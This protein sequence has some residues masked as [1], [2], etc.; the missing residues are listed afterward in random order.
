MNDLRTL[1][2]DPFST[3]FDRADEMS[4]RDDWEDWDDDAPLSPTDTLGEERLVALESQTA[5]RPTTKASDRPQYRSSIQ[6]PARLKS[7]LRQK[8]QNERAGIKLVTDM[9]KFKKQ[10]QQQ[11]HIAQQMRG[12]GGVPDR[13]TGKFVNAAALRALEGSPNESSV[14]NWHWL[15]RK[16]AGGSRSTKSPQNQHGR[17]GSDLSPDDRPIVIGIAMPED[18]LAERTISPQTATLDSPPAGLRYPFKKKAGPGPQTPSEQTRSVW[19][20]DTPDGASPYAARRS[21]AASSSHSQADAPAGGDA[22]PVPG[23]PFHYQHKPSVASVELDDDDNFSPITLFEEDGSPST[24]SPAKKKGHSRSPATVGAQSGWWDHVQ[25]PFVEQQQSNNPFAPKPKSPE[26]EQPE[27]KGEWWKDADEKKAA[28]P[29]R[30]APGLG[31]ATSSTPSTTSR[32]SPTVASSSRSPP[33]TQPESFFDKARILAEEDQTPTE[34]RPPYEAASKQPVKYRAVFPPGH[35][36]RNQ[37]PPSPGPVSPAMAG[38]MTSQGAISLTVVPLTPAPRRPELGRGDR[39]MPAGPR[40]SYAGADHFG[41]AAGSS[42]AAKIERQ[43]RRHEKE[44]A[45]ARR[46]EGFW[47]GRGCIPENGCYG[48]RG[49]EGRQRR[50]IWCIVVA[51][52]L[53][54]IVL[55]V[56]LAVALTHRSPTTVLA[57]TPLSTFL[58]ISGF[59]PIPTGVNTVVGP[60]SKLVDGCVQPSTLWTCS[61][62]KEQQQSNKP[63]QADQP[64]FIFQIQYDSNPRQLWNV[65]DGVI[66]TP[67]V[68]A[69]STSSTR[70]SA[71]DTSPSTSPLFISRHRSK[72]S[73]N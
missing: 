37:F 57:D 26:D 35:P 12:A 50:R 1:Q 16:Q 56:A 45:M 71:Y 39:P 58:N 46:V 38:T 69:S 5:A 31:I 20:P 22:P 67:T 36:L 62:P 30:A 73:Q 9:S 2:H 10:Q 65:P 47:K 29:R 23:V 54:A 11:Q 7:R 21:R 32:L 55:A 68:A 8:A 70:Y 44:D 53:V 27:H 4:G 6:K 18:D 24:R 28:S 33:P 59:P 51:A 48:R 15:K 64:E 63:Y 13:R 60:D 19:S 17:K 42:P 41:D 43:R 25:T 66:P 3:P 72:A 40:G 34:E 61:L 49:R 52:L 14:G